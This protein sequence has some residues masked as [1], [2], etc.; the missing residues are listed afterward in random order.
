MADSVWQVV[1][2]ALAGGVV[3]L[4][5]AGVVF[6]AV[7]QSR[8]RRQMSQQSRFEA[9]AFADRVRA[10]HEQ[11]KSSASQLV[12]CIRELGNL[13]GRAGDVKRT[14]LEKGVAERLKSAEKLA[15]N[16]LALMQAEPLARASSDL[17]AICTTLERQR[18]QIQA[19]CARI[20]EKNGQPSSRAMASMR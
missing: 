13:T 9:T 19:Q 11:L 3:L 8:L 5:V 1:L 4:W 2:G 6:R 10:D 16:A 14:Q 7:A 17:R 15:M 12:H 20:Q 18:T